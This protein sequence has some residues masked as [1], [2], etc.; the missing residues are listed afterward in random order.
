MWLLMIIIFYEG[1]IGGSSYV[2]CFMNILKNVDP[3]E[4]EFSLGSVSIS[5]SS[6]TLISAF[7]GI[8]LEPTLCKHQ[9]DTGRPWCRME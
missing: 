3:K 8:Y 4:R 6:G 2:N 5:D 7:L 1:L 9:V